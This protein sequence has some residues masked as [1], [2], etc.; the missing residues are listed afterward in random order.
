MGAT[1][2][3]EEIQN[4]GRSKKIEEVFSKIVAL[5]KLYREFNDTCKPG[6]LYRET[7]KKADMLRIVPEEIAQK[8]RIDIDN[9]DEINYE[10]ML[11]KI[12][13]YV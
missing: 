1:L 6:E 2:I 3:A 11:A 4:I 7:E 13:N 12:N 10:P 9:I 8:L 5:E